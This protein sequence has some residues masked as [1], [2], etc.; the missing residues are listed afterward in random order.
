MDRRPPE[1]KEFQESVIHIARVARVVKG[2]RRFRFRALVAIGNGQDKVGIGIAKG[3]D[4]QRA[5]AKAVESAHK[6]LIQVPIA[7]ETIPHEALTKVAGSSVFL[8]PAAP[9]TG[10]IAGGTVRSI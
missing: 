4:V 10:I 2:G 9:G 8:K 5:I 7:E 6:Q 1:T 3:S